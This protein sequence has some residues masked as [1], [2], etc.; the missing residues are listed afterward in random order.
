MCH[1][2]GRREIGLHARCWWENVKE[3]DRLEDLGV[4]MRVILKCLAFV[5][6]C[7]VSVITIDNQQDAT[8]LIYLFLIRST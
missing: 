2:R 7:I 8:I 5:F 1:V 6:P 3:R 4:E